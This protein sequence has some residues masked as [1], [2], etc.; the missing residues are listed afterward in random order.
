MHRV[1]P[2]RYRAGH[3]RVRSLMHQ[4]NNM[5]VHRWVYYAYVVRFVVMGMLLDGQLGLGRTFI[6][7]NTFQSMSCG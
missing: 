2:G 6:A 5:S 3:S 1:H 7:F 4:V